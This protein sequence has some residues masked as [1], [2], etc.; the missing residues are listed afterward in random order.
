[1]NALPVKFRTCVTG[2]IPLSA[3]GEESESDDMKQ[4]QSF[5]IGKIALQPNPS[6]GVFTLS[7]FTEFGGHYHAIIKSSVGETAYTTQ[8]LANA[9]WNDLNID[10][11]SFGAG[12]YSIGVKGEG[13]NAFTKALVQ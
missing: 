9:G 3:P 7:F 13:I 6:D 2:I 11:S 4:D 12:I 1:L 5:V 10:L 8:G